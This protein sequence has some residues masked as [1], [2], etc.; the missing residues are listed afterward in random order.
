MLIGLGSLS[1]AFI[2]SFFLAV[3]LLG[4]AGWYH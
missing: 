1:L 2:L 3:L 4:E